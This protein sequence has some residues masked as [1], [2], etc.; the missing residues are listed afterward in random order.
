MKQGTANGSTPTPSV[1]LTIYST[2][3]AEKARPK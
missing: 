3:T 1:V 2:N